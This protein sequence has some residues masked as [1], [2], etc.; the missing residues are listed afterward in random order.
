[1]YFNDLSNIRN[2]RKLFYLPGFDIFL[3]IFDCMYFSIPLSNN[4]QKHK[5][6]YKTYI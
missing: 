5:N 6:M 2:R 3:G 4:L 1:M